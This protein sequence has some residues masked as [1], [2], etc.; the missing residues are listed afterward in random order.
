MNVEHGI[1]IELHYL[2]MPYTSEKDILR[3][4]AESFTRVGPLSEVAL[5]KARN[6]T[7]GHLAR[8]CCAIRSENQ[9]T[10]N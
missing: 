9:N 5:F 3:F 7:V 1:A 2:P 8:L 10:F 4:Q 6:L